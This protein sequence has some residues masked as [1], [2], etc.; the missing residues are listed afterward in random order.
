MTTTT[1]P[2]VAD[3][4]RLVGDRVRLLDADPDLGALLDAERH[5]RAG[6]Q[7]VV[8]TRRIRLGECDVSE[9]AGAGPHDVG[10][11]ILDGVVSREVVIG[12][13]LSVE[14]LGPGDLVRPPR[15]EPA[16]LLAVRAVWH[17]RSPLTVAL[18]DRR[19]ALVTAQYP[20]IAC[21]L[22]ER[23]GERAVR[24]ATTQAISQL[25]GVDRRLTALLWHL[26]ERWGRVSRDG[27]ILPLGLNHAFLGQLVGARRPTVSTALAELSRRGEIVRRT[28]GGWLLVGDPP[29]REALARRG[30]GGAP[31]PLALATRF[32]RRGLVVT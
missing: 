6:E 17:V 21:T 30:S 3:T 14:L 9:L 26:A 18:L 28:D 27:I 15:P 5:K 11:L 4:L 16:A 10:L 7:L 31:T 23:L 22:F 8:H 13:R 32:S 24:L 19:F 1:T 25:T 29:G 2:R 20:E 12:E